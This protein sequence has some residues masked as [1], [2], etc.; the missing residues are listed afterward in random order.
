MPCI[1]Q[2]TVCAVA[3]G[4]YSFVQRLIHSTACTNT[5]KLGRSYLLKEEDAVCAAI[6]RETAATRLFIALAAVR[7]DSAELYTRPQPNEAATA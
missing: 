3:T 1:F 2:Q 4:A 7:N 6:R 5:H